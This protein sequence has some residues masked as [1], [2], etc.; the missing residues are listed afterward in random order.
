MHHLSRK[1]VTPVD[2]TK[3]D[4]DLQHYDPSLRAELERRYKQKV[5]KKKRK[6][7]ST[8]D[9][10]AAM[11]EDDDFGSVEILA[12]AKAELM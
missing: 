3:L 10:A 12:S 2:P 9:K 5:N 4:A 8:D 11:E 7:S 1:V 6:A